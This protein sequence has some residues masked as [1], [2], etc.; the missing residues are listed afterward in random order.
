LPITTENMVTE[1]GDDVAKM[2]IKVGTNA[3]KFVGSVDT[4]EN[5]TE[6]SK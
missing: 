6:V 2:S 3:V 4:I 1:S 5:D